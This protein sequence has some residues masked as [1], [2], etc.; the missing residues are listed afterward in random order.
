[1]A[2]TRARPFAEMRTRY[3]IDSEDWNGDV[4]AMKFPA[5][6]NAEARTTFDFGTGYA[7]IHRNDLPAARSAFTDLQAASAALSAD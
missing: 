7:A 4:A 6:G 3:L 2:K 5:N 1:M